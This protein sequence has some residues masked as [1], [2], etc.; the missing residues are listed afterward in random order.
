MKP[1]KV[2]G[3]VGHKG[4][5]VKIAQISPTV[6]VIYTVVQEDWGSIKRRTILWFRS[7]E[8]TDAIQ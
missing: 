8:L 5:K 2:C 4:L 7:A 3:V 1:G 6:D